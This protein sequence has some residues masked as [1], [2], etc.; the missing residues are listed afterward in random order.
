MEPNKVWVQELTLVYYAVRSLVNMEKI[1]E[2]EDDIWPNLG[3]IFAEHLVKLKMKSFQSQGKKKEMVGSLL[4]PI[5]IHCG[6]PLDD[7]AMDDKIIYMDAAH[8]TS[9]QWLKDDRY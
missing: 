3:A 7:A 1:A 5:F 9:A 2:P 4:T 8:L 6:V